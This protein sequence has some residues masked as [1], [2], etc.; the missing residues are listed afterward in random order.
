MFETAGLRS[1]ARRSP[2]APNPGPD[3]GSVCPVAALLGRADQTSFPETSLWRRHV[4]PGLEILVYTD[5]GLRG[6]SYRAFHRGLFQKG[7]NTV[8]EA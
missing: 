4:F 7:R 8:G 5:R 1:G 2:R 3:M 6:C